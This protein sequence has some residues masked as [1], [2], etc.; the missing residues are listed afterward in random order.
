MLIHN[1]NFEGERPKLG[2][3]ELSENEARV[4]IDCDL[5]SGELRPL[6]AP[7]SVASSSVANAKTIVQFQGEW[8]AFA[9]D[10]D[11]IEE[12]NNLF[13]TGPEGARR[14]NITQLRLG[15]SSP[16]G[17]P[18]PNLDAENFDVSGTGNTG[19]TIEDVAYIVSFVNSD[20]D[21]G[22]NEDLTEL[23]QITQGQTLTINGLNRALPANSELIDEY[24]IVASRIYFLSQGEFRFLAEVPVTQTSFT[25]V[26]GDV[27]LGEV[28]ATNNFNLPPVGGTSLHRMTNGISLMVVP[29]QNLVA[30]SE[31]FNANAWPFFFPVEDTPVAVS[32]YDNYAVVVTD[33]YPEVA[34]INDP[35][36]IIPTTLTYREPCLNK[37]SLVQGAGGVI[38]ASD[39]GAFY[40]GRGG[41]RLLTEDHIDRKDWQR[42][43]PSSIVAAFADGQ[44][45]AFHEDSLVEGNALVIDTREPRAFVRQL[46]QSTR[47]VFVLP[48]TDEVYVES[49]SV[50]IQLEGS[51]V[52]LTYKWQSK[53]FGDGSPFALIARRLLA[54]DHVDRAYVE[55]DE[56]ALQLIYEG[57]A[58]EIAVRSNFS[59]LYGF[60]GSLNGQVLAGCGSH[61]VAGTGIFVDRG[62]ALGGDSIRP[63]VPSRNYRVRL[64]VW[65]DKELV[66]E[67]QI[68]ND[69]NENRLHY[70]DRGRFIH[71]CL[72]GQLAVQQIDLAGSNSEMYSGT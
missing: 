6:N 44:Y 69:E 42:Y 1:R 17:V 22:D 63:S 53:L 27:V 57:R 26:F 68:I 14:A 54:C 47:A 60:G 9:D 31:P 5:Q 67:E 30:V 23:F 28:F 58:L 13:W 34:A 37:N 72:E 32:S 52:P 36:N 25:H 51:D 64:T 56:A 21:E 11:I 8:F 2:D 38:Y 20:G 33:G 70:F 66:H 24:Q 18:A 48:G 65:R 12:G 29:D 10:I 46:S 55:L 7:T 61:E 35:Q 43:N 19:A 50:I 49:Q 39:N 41:G 62:A 3:R 71:Y 59:P 40:I 45:Y 4:A 15:L 16:M